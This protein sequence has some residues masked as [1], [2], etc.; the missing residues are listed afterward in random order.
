VAC[1]IAPCMNVA[2]LL[3]RVLLVVCPFSLE[4][5]TC[6]L[7]SDN[8]R[9]LIYFTFHQFVS[10]Y[11]MPSCYTFQ[12]GGINIRECRRIVISAHTYCMIFAH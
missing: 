7:M 10:C 11:L 2:A 12:N 6:P 4:S 5:S 1:A 8:Y 3:R 9:L